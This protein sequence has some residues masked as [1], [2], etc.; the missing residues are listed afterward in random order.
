MKRIRLD[1]DTGIGLYL[2]LDKLYHISYSGVDF[3]S[4]KDRRRAKRVWELLNNI[5]RAN[6]EL[7]QVTSDVQRNHLQLVIGL[8][9]VELDQ[10]TGTCYSG[11]TEGLEE[12]EDARA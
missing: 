5:V 11:K 12:Q 1:P 2:G 7:E 10:L 9:R 6:I 3:W 4:C 8:Y